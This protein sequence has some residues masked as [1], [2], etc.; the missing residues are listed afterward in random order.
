MHER[1]PAL[2][3]C[4]MC[5]AIYTFIDGYNYLRFFS[6]LPY[7]EM[8]SPRCGIQNLN[9][10]S[11]SASTLFPSFECRWRGNGPMGGGVMD[12]INRD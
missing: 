2:R 9:Y 5:Y 7:A 10:F 6:L 3:R 4:S 11:V 1:R 12:N 8:K